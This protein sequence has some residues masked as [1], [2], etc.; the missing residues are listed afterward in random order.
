MAD[1]AQ[2]ALTDVY[3]GYCHAFDALGV[4]Y[5]AYPLQHY[6]Q[7]HK[8][9]ICFSVVHSEALMKDN[10]Y[11]H[12]FFIGGLNIPRRMLAS[13]HSAVKVVIIATEDPHTFD[14]LR[15]SLEFIDYY[16]SNERAVTKLGYKNVFYCPTAADHVTCGAVPKHTLDSKY[17]S[18][19]LFLGAIYPNRRKMLEAIIPFVKKHGLNL[20]VLGHPQ[21]LP[22][23]SPIWEFVPTANYDAVGNIRTIPHEETVKYYSGSRAILNF[24]RDVTWNPLFGDSKNPFNAGSIVPESMNPRAYEVPMCGSLMLLEDSRVE[25]REVFTDSEVGFFSTPKEL[26]ELFKKHLLTKGSI[27]TNVRM[28]QAAYI[29]V[30]GS[31]TYVS[32][33]R[34]ILRIIS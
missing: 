28:I 7:H 19:I 25:A 29:K 8:E 10:G 22:K 33:A 23:T 2:F 31:H 27:V 20:K 6:L 15:G 16:F 9:H 24:Y 32:R 30:S 18:D 5:V 34:E 21:Y 3:Y 4:D 11:T 12:V 1:A 14:P 26:R 17:F 13:F